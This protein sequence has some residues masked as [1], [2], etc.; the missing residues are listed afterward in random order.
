MAELTLDDT[1]WMP[2]LTGSAIVD[3]LVLVD[4]QVTWEGLPFAQASTAVRTRVSVAIGMAL[5]PKCRVI[6]V[7]NGNDLDHT[8]LGLLADLAK[9]YQCQVWVERI[10]GGAGL[11]TIVIEDGAVKA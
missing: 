10:E 11:P 7:R 4:G 2:S 6:L 8:R 5:N 9:K 1:R 3:G